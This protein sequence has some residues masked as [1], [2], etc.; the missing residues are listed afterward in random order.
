MIGD[1]AGKNIQNI[2]GIY[3]TCTRVLLVFVCSKISSLVS[4]RKNAKE[5]NVC[6]WPDGRFKPRISFRSTL[7]FF[8]LSLMIDEIRIFWFPTF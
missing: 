7:K 5:K 3:K 4:K 8:R 2:L 6:A 1:L